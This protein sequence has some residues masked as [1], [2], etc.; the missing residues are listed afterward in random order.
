MAVTRQDMLDLNKLAQS[1]GF[2]TCRAE[3]IRIIGEMDVP[4]NA[5]I[6]FENVIHRLAALDADNFYKIPPTGGHTRMTL[7][8][9]QKANRLKMLPSRWRHVQAERKRR[10]SYHSWLAERAEPEPVEVDERSLRGFNALIQ[11]DV[12]EKGINHGT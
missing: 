9:A 8:Q 11:A 7:T 10:D 5:L 3:V 1:A 2:D 12:M 6:Y 4:S